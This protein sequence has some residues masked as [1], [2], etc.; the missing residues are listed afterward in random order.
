MTQ[1][2]LVV[3]DDGDVR[4]L[5]CRMLEQDGYEA[6]PAEGGRQALER[7][8]LI[9]PDLVITDVVMPEVDGFEVLLKLRHLAPRAGALVMSGGGRV[10]P[11]LYLETARRLG[12]SAVL[13]KPFTR[14]EMLDAVH[15]ILGPR[16]TPQ[17]P[18]QET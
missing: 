17:P 8:N 6:V 18:M 5:V 15:Q 7:L 12:A 14:A 4:E 2:I 1:R 11:D 9:A 16:Q 10:A 3:D 13:R